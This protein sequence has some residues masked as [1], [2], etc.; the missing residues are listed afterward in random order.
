M[1]NLYLIMN[2]NADS[3]PEEISAALEDLAHMEPEISEESKDILLAPERKAVY[4]S[5]HTQ[6]SIFAAIDFP[7]D[8]NQEGNQWSKRLVEFSPLNDEA[9]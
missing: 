5:L 7:P 2:T 1:R 8:T 9:G 4:D 3:S 6:F